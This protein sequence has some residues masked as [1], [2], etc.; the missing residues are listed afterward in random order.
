MRNL[1]AELTCTLSPEQR[2]HHPQVGP[3]G[4]YLLE[5]DDAQS[6]VTYAPTTGYTLI[7]MANDVNERLS[8]AARVF[9]APARR[10]SETK[11]WPSER[12]R[13]RRNPERLGTDYIDLMIL[14]QPTVAGY[15]IPRR[16]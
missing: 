6:A 1:T 5:P 10:F 8:V 7:D 11:L 14:H 12:H 16:Q 15:R 13:R 9:Q 2:R 3:F 4:T